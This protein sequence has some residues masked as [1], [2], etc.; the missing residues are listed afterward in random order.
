MFHAEERNKQS[1][2]AVERNV[3]LSFLKYKAPRRRRTTKINSTM[4]TIKT[5]ISTIAFDISGFN[6][7]IKRH[8]TSER[9]KKQCPPVCCLQETQFSFKD[10]C[11]LGGKGWTTA[12]QPNV[13]KEQRVITVLVCDKIDSKRN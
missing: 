1:Q 12:L 7:L 2:D 9:I 8:R 3:N 6:P 11:H 5:Y 13:A 10:R 4:A